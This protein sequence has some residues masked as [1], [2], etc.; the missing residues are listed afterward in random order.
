MRVHA[1]VGLGVDGSSSNNGA[2]VLAE[3]RQALLLQRVKNGAD[4]FTPED[5]LRLATLGGAKLLNRT[6]EL[7]N[8]AA[9]HVADLAIFDLNTVEYAGAAV[10]DPLGAL[11]M[12]HAQRAKFVIV[13]GRVVVNYGQIATVNTQQLVA[14]VNDVVRKR[15]S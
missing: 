2:H 15:F 4:S 12:C 3:A 5:A 6:G 7:G 11:M 8:L 10:Q 9:S 13:N 1:T 14:R